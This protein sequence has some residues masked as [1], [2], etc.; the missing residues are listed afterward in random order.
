MLPRLRLR[1]LEARLI[2]GGTGAP[3]FRTWNIS[4]GVTLVVLPTYATGALL[5]DVAAG[6]QQPAL[7]S[8][9]L[10]RYG[11]ALIHGSVLLASIQNLA[12]LDWCASVTDLS[13]AA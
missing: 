2:L 7:H 3:R 9:W 6:L 12:V 5:F 8:T 1:S 10:R 4:G 11:T 13:P